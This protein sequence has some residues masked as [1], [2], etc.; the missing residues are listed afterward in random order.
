MPEFSD[1]K[2]ITWHFSVF[3]E[4]EIGYDIVIVR[5]LMKELGMDIS[6]TKESVSWEVIEIPMRDFNKLRKW[7][8]Y[9][10][11]MKAII[12]E[13]S[14][15]IVTQEATERIL[16]I[17]DSKYEKA[18]LRLVVDGAK[19]LTPIEREKL[20]KLLVKYQI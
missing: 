15:P 5:D 13:S 10:M 9:N 19:N 6:F 16:T 20:Y 12:Q 7:N 8:I 11:E 14:E 3:K 18:N 2:N 17:L 4:K 1:K